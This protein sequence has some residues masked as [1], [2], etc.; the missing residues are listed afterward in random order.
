MSYLQSLCSF[1]CNVVPLRSGESEWAHPDNHTHGGA[2]H[3]GIK[4]THNP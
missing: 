3:V 4:L 1:K 2:L